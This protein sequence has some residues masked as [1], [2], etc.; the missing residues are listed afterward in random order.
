MSSSLGIAIPRRQ[1]AELRIGRLSVPGATYFVTSCTARRTPSLVS[2]AACAAAHA[3]CRTLETDGDAAICA[4][5]VMPDHVHL[6][7]RLGERLTLDRVVAKW[8]AD[9]RRLAPECSWQANY[10]EHRLRTNERSERYAWYIF[11]NPYRARLI[12][13]DESWPGWWPVSLNAWRF[14]SAALPGPRPHPEWLDEIEE[15]AR[16]LVTGET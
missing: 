13:T 4:A 2:P 5:T 6:L 8:K 7:L 14:L 10:Y 9:V 12:S 11:M 1:T 16:T 15:V 3:A